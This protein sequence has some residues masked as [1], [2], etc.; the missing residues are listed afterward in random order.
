MG[1]TWAMFRWVNGE[2]EFCGTTRHDE[3]ATEFEEVFCE[4]QEPVQV[5]GLEDP[6]TGEGD[7][8]PSLPKSKEDVDD[9]EV[10]DNLL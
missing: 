9:V 3:L 6:S 4:E 5:V 2:W 1:V 7:A 10:K 8:T